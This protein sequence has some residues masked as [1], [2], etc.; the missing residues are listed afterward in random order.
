MVSGLLELSSGDIYY[1]FIRFLIGYYSSRSSSVQ[2]GSS[3]IRLD[4]WLGV[5]VL[6][7][8]MRCISVAGYGLGSGLYQSCD[9]AGLPCRRHIFCFMF[10]HSLS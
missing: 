5:I 9:S 10:C 1:Y 8:V 4:S 6:Q 3:I 2:F 7:L